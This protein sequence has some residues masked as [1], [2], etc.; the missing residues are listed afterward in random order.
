MFSLPLRNQT[1]R[2]I[3]EFKNFTSKHFGLGKIHL[4]FEKMN[5]NGLRQMKIIIV[6]TFSTIFSLSLYSSS[7]IN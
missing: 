3:P 4:T 5:L 2:V 1:R 6:G 7:D